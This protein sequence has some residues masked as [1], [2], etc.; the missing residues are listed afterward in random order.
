MLSATLVGNSPPIWTRRSQPEHGIPDF[1]S[2]MRSRNPV[3]WPKWGIQNRGFRALVAT[4]AVVG[5]SP[6][7]LDEYPTVLGIILMQSPRTWATLSSFWCNMVIAQTTQSIGPQIWSE[8][9]SSSS[10][11]IARLGTGLGWCVHSMPEIMLHCTI[12]N[13]SRYK[14]TPKSP[15]PDSSFASPNGVSCPYEHL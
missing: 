13:G 12:I 7:I 1:I 3:F 15:N 4:R 9:L 10:K 6:L 11:N 2:F 5:N 14:Q 8:T